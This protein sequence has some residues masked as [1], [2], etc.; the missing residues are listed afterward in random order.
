MHRLL[1]YL[2]D[3]VSSSPYYRRSRYQMVAMVENGERRTARPMEMIEL[4]TAG[5]VNRHAKNPLEIEWESWTEERERVEV[6]K[7]R[8]SWSQASHC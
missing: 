4:E 6:R 3:D 7:E 2:N 5:A 8:G 1:V